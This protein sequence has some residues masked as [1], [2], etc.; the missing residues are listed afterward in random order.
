M[1]AKITVVCAL[2]HTLICELFYSIRSG[3]NTA[4]SRAAINVI[5][6]GVEDYNLQLANVNGALVIKNTLCNRSESFAT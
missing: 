5:N 1:L 6:N 4:F 3:V 2:M